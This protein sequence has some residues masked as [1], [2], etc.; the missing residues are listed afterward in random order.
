MKFTI[1][2]REDD[3]SNETAQEVRFKMEKIG[4]QFDDEKPDFVITVGGDGTLLYAFH[5]YQSRLS[6]VAFVGIHTGHLGFYADWTTDEIDQLV[7]AIANEPLQIVEYPLLDVTVS[8]LDNAQEIMYLALNEATIKSSIGSAMVVDVEVQN[9]EF[10]TFRGDGLCFSTPSGSTAYNKSLGGAILHP[11]IPAMQMAEMA[12][13]NN[14]V[15]RTIGSSLVIP[16][17][18][19]CVLKPIVKNEFYMTIDHLQ[20]FHTGVRTVE[21]RVSEETIRFA[22]FRPHPFWKRVK[23]A[24]VTD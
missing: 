19:S 24:F 18:H 16:K 5:H 12:S 20:A 7:E 1:I 8:F 3:H 13:I 15:Y 14:R 23:N 17:Y 11:N 21:F 10:E 4:L 22:R 6:E 9:T 2:S